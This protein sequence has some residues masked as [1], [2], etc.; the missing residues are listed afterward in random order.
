M[1]LN[2]RGSKIEVTDAIKNYLESKLSKLDKYFEK[3]ED[4][5]ANVVIRTRGISQII[6]VTIPIK[7]AVLRAEESNNDLYASIDFAVDKLE[8]QIRKNKTKIKQKANKENVDVF[9]DFEIDEDEMATETI[10]KRKTI[11]T[12]PMSEEEAILQMELVGHEFFAFKNIDTDS[13]S[14]LYKR[15][16]GNYGIIEMK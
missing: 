3:T 16:D 14:V 2:I 9:I 8:R 13:M 7:K 5:T 4:I 1:K 10:V 6:E 11:D 15:K 12:K